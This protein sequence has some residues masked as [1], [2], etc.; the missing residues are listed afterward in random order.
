MNRICIELEVQSALFK[1]IYKCQ[2]FRALV[3]SINVLR[4]GHRHSPFARPFSLH[5]TLQLTI[6]ILPISQ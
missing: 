4:H 5:Y 2:K 6:C 3:I 1:H